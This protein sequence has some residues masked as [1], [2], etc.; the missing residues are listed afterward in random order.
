MTV[1]IFIFKILEDCLSIRIYYSWR[2]SKP[3][4][5]FLKNIRIK[6]LIFSDASLL[7]I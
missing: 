1:P 5:E 4:D 7:F 3:N 6:I 2:F